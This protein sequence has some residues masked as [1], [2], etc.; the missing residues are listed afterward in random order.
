MPMNRKKEINI[1]IA[2]MLP[3]SVSVTDS[4]EEE[5]WLEAADRVNHLWSSWAKR[6]PEKSSEEV[7]GMVTL[8]F[9]QAFVI[10]SHAEEDLSSTLSDFESEIDK[11][12]RDGAGIADQ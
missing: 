9:A 11:I 4:S 3:F 5:I 2:N 7:L 6:F 10:H 1:R 8:R 12:L